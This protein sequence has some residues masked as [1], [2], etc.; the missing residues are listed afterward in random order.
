MQFLNSIEYE[1][2]LTSNLKINREHDMQIVVL[3]DTTI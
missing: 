3:Y 2:L 1:D